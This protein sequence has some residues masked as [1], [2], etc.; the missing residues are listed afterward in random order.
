[1]GHENKVIVG[2]FRLHIIGEAFFMSQPGHQRG[3]AL[4]FPW[5]NARVYFTV[6]LVSSKEAC[7]RF[8]LPFAIGEDCQKS[9]LFEEQ[10]PGFDTACFPKAK[11]TCCQ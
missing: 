2:A 9:I 3:M 5:L 8:P 11:N 10:S 4:Y 7:K 1:M 6:P